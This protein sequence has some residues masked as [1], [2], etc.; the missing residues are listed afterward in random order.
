ML[1]LCYFLLFHSTSVKYIIYLSLVF[2]LFFFYDITCNFCYFI[3]FYLSVKNVPC[4]TSIVTCSKYST[5]TI[6]TGSHQE[7][8]QLLK[9]TDVKVKKEHK[10]IKV[11]MDIKLLVGKWGKD[12]TLSSTTSLLSLFISFD[13]FII[14]SYLYKKLKLRNIFRLLIPECISE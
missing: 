2:I 11:K 14:L 9:G 12:L 3:L 1:K 7:H 10:R 6:G 4:G 13:G 5:L 8:I